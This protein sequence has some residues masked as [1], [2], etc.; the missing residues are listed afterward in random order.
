MRIRRNCDNIA[1][2]NSQ[3]Q[4]IINRFQE[5]GYRPKELVRTQQE[6]LQLNIDVMLQDKEKRTNNY[7]LA[8]MTGLQDNISRVDSIISKH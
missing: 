7:G 1:E 8:F 6:V 2:C 5:K 4:I 3:A